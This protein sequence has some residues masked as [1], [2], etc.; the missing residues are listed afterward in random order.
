MLASGFNPRWRAALA[1]SERQ[2]LIGGR[3]P[4]RLSS[5]RDFG[6]RGILYL[7]LK[8]E[9]IVYR[10]SATLRA[11]RGAAAYVSLGF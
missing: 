5:L 4:S 7:G 2:Q 1:H 8:S 3:L 9:A 11:S 6:G 10:G